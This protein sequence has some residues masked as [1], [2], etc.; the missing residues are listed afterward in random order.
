M[1]KAHKWNSIRMNSSKSYMAFM[2]TTTAPSHVIPIDFNE[3]ISVHRALCSLGCAASA[4]GSNMSGPS[5]ASEGV[6]TAHYV[7]PTTVA[8]VLASVAKK[9]E[10]LF[11]V[12]S[13]SDHD[14]IILLIRPI[15]LIPDRGPY[16]EYSARYCNSDFL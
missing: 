7:A 3:K 10:I 16:V 4:V 2:R 11:V 12:F 5:V 1:R 6:G 14:H 13:L 8:S 9:C 15:H